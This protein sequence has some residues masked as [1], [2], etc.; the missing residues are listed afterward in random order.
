LM[1]WIHAFET[2][3]RFRISWSASLPIGI[4]V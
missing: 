1:F 3:R 2:R 4:A